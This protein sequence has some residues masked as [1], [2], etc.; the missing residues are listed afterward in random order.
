MKRRVSILT[1]RHVWALK[2]AL[3]EGYEDSV[4]DF[5][6][7]P[8]LNLGNDREFNEKVRYAIESN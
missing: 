2:Y 6:D 7:T 8:A 1:A 5:F 3:M 4:P